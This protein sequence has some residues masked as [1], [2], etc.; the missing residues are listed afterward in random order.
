MKFKPENAIDGKIRKPKQ[1][2][3]IWSPNG[4]K[5]L[6]LQGVDTGL[7]FSSFEFKPEP[8]R[9]NVKWTKLDEK[10]LSSSA[11]DRLTE[12]VREELCKSAGIPKSY[13]YGAIDSTAEE[14]RKKTLL[15]P[16][17]EAGLE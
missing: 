9:L 17:A 2:R 5:P 15:G 10:I 14:N 7:S 6:P 12:Y 8:R 3:K 11:Q 13:I 1:L 16:F 4:G